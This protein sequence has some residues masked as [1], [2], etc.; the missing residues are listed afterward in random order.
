MP[1]ERYNP[2]TR[3]FEDSG[4]RS[5]VVK[6]EMAGKDFSEIERKKERDEF[7]EEQRKKGRKLSFAYNVEKDP[8]FKTWRESRAKA[9]GQQKAMAGEKSGEKKVAAEE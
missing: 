8:E 5:S 2:T 4:A 1:D 9:R 3:R 7:M 6:G